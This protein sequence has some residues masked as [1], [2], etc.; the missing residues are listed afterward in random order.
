MPL[1]LVPPL[2]RATHRI[3]LFLEGASEV[4]VTQAEA[5][6]LSH[7]A[8]RDGSCAIG[9]LHRSFGHKRSTLTS[10][11]DRLERARLVERS[12]HPEDRRSF[13]LRLTPRGRTAARSVLG[14]LE[15]LE[16]RALRR[17][18]AAELSGFFAVLAA[19]EA[20]AGARS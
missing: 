8:E 7:L 3:A 4:G 9:D 15:G 17:V 10:I 13:L 5:H 11:V 18:T 20:A 14:V 1:R 19:I 12:I 16:Q 2:H 6:V